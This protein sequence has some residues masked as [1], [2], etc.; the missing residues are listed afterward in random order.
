MP[1]PR[2]RSRNQPSTPAAG[3]N[4]PIPVASRAAE[5]KASEPT[6]AEPAVAEFIVTEPT[7]AEL[8]VAEFTVAEP[9][10]QDQPK[11][12]RRPGPTTTAQAI[13]RHARQLFSLNGYAKTTLRDIAEAAGVDA[14]LIFHFFG[15]KRGLFDAATE[16]PL[17]PDMPA[18]AEFRNSTEDPVRRLARMYFTLWGTDEVA[19]ALSAIIIEAAHDPAAARAMARFMYTWV[20]GPLVEELGVDQPELRLRLMVGFMAAIALQRHFDPHCM[21][22]ALTLEQVVDLAEPT[23]RFVLASPLHQEAA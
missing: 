3:S 13:L 5:L 9:T 19:Q 22:A 1:Q 16:V 20:G 23:M 21:L 6:A 14:K 10:N 11:P 18:L 4:E 12:G 15:S 7:V 8:D 2:N 17:D